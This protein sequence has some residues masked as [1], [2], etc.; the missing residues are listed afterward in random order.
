MVSL[1]QDL[2]GS[3]L[4]PVVEVRAN[5]SITLDLHGHT[6]KLDSQGPALGVPGGTPL[7]IIDSVGGG[8]LIAN[9]ESDDAAIGGWGTDSS[10]TTDPGYGTIV[11]SGPR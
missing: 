9:S 11:I 8:A 7:T 4:D 10:P 2:T 6:L 5:A 3:Q 1:T